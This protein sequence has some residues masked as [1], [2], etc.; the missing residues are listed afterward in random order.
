MKILH[1]LNTN[2]FSGAES[3][4]CTIIKNMD[5]QF[6]MIYCSPDGP[7]RNKL[8]EENI[9]FFSLKKLSCK[10]VKK[11]IKMIKPD[12]IHAHDYRC[13]LYAALCKK[14]E[15]LI[16]HLH[17]NSPWIKKV[18]INSFIF[19]FS[20]I[21]SNKVLLV[22]KSILDEFIF[23]K[24]LKSKAKIIGN[25][26]CRNQI[27]SK[28]SMQNKVKTFD[29]CCVARLS[30]EKN[31][32]R[33]LSIIE[34]LSK[35]Q[36]SLK[37]VWVGDGNL[38]TTVLEKVKEKK[39]DKFIDF[40]GFQSNPYEYLNNSK[41]FLLT[42]DWEG[43]GLSAFEALTLGVPCVVS[44]VGGLTEIVDNSCGKLCNT[45]DI[46]E[47]CDEI[48]KLLTDEKYYKNKSEAAT[49]KSKKI[50]NLDEY[51]SQLE[52]TYNSLCIN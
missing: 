38:K 18:S 35:K 2:K 17:N 48:E 23:K 34:E 6:D 45:N 3:V 33:F 29:I 30:T 7:I 46:Y 37:V 9:S 13:A 27:L 10:E 50:E 47:Y 21:S 36:D 20:I 43:F 52:K 12:I 51:V 32:Y 8:N 44:K 28:L 42:S 31:P 19:L 11:A 4:V 15:K 22:S 1:L 24:R 14:N 25:P 40:V 49:I 41:I 5:K 39:L 16:I 26:I